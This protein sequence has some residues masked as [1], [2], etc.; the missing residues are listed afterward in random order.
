MSSSRA[1]ELLKYQS[2]LYFTILLS[3]LA[4]TIAATFRQQASARVFARHFKSDV[5]VFSIVLFGQCWISPPGA[6]TEVNISAADSNAVESGQVP[7]VANIVNLAAPHLALRDVVDALNAA[8]TGPNIGI[9]NVN[10]ILGAGIYRLGSTLTLTPDPS[11]NNTT[12][13]FSAAAG[14]TVVISGSQPVTGFVPASSAAARA[15]LPAIAQGQVMVASLAQN[16]ITKLGTFQ[17]H[18]FDIPVTPAPLELFYQGQPM[19]L[20]RWP[21]TG[22][23]TIATLP[24]GPTGLTFTITGAPLDAWQNEPALMAMGYWARDWA[25]TTLAIQAVDPS[26]GTIT[27]TGPAPKFGLL[28]GQRVFIENAL[29]SLD[30]PGD[31]YVDTQ[32]ALVYFWPPAPLQNGDIEVSVVNSL[33]VANNANNLTISN[34]TFENGRGD[35]LQFQGGGNI[36]VTHTAILNM[37]NRAAISNAG[38]S[39][40]SFLTVTNTGEGGLVINNG[41]RTTLAAGN[42]YVTDST[43]SNFARRTRAYRPAIN[44]SGVGNQILRNTIYNGPH[45]AIIFSGNNHLISDNEIHDVVTE[46]TDSGAIYS[47][48]DW[49]MRGTVI[50]DNFI[51]D[52][53]NTVQPHATMGIYLDDEICGTVIRRNVFSNVNDA[54]FI[55]GGRDNLVHDNLFANLSPAIYIDS[56]GLSWQNAW[57][58]NPSGMFQTELAAVNYTRSPYSTRYPTLPYILSNFPGAPLGNVLK[59]NIFIN[60]T[61]TA[62]DSGALPYLTIESMFGASDVIFTT[63]MDNAS[64]TRF[65]QFRLAPSSPAIRQGFTPSLFSGP[66]QN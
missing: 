26:S 2:S 19:T 34:L 32:N 18:G 25:D 54:V 28:A 30:Q 66:F 59:Q 23:A 39:S 1:T 29:S 61:A 57:V 60:S 27:L 6:A 53:G 16:G 12:I 35:G 8:K 31:Y 13:S 24:D 7:P 33:W 14:T 21:D 9:S 3:R 42:N 37:G 17:P 56:R 51:H 36:L 10:V 44:L 55:G 43:L 58:L 11:W 50:Q 15:R 52:I 38:S 64:R 46:T 41:N 22:F 65:P 63:P 49:T 20:A 4:S 45:S 5:T 62:I 40:F 47:G 48:R